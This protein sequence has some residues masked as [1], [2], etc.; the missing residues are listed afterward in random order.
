MILANLYDRDGG[1]DTLE[2]LQRSLVKFN[3]VWD[4]HWHR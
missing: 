3:N 1:D 2:G 4:T